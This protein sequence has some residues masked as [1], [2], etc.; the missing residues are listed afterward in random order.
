MMTNEQPIAT[1][2]WARRTAL[3]EMTR[4]HLL[5]QG[6]TFVWCNTRT[7]YG[8]TRYGGRTIELSR[9]MTA[10]RT[11]VSVRDTILHEIAHALVGPGHGH[12]SE[13]KAV[14]RRIGADPTRV[15]DDI[16]VRGRYVAV[17]PACAHTY[18]AHRMGKN[19]RKG[20]T[21]CGVCK[22]DIAHRRLI[23]HDTGV[24]SHQGH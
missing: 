6:W 3:E 18:D 12:G 23:W 4:H 21:A 13:W 8:Q 15:R 10:G 20:H 22:G 5:G 2:A 17:C 14:C 19:M 11:Q 16:T 9:Y 24:V 7:R 1:L